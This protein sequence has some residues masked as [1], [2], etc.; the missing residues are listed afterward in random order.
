MSAAETKDADR[1]ESFENA[2]QRLEAIVQQ[3]EKGELTLEDSLKLY[4]EGIRLS[5]LCHE[6]LEEAEGRIE[7][8]VKNARGEVAID[9][10][11]RPRK[12]PFAGSGEPGPDAR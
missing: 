3:L 6:R 11:G 7:L 4:E 9:R 5:R 8:L 10:D 12:R 2:L 1:R